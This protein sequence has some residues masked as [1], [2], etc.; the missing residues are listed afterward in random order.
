MHGT[1]LA[2]IKGDLSVYSI[3]VIWVVGSKDDTPLY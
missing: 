1:K 3:A 2:K